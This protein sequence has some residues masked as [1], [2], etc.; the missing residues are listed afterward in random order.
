MQQEM[1]NNKMQVIEGND[2]IFRY[3]AMNNFIRN[4]ETL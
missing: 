4:M 1:V 2:L 3:I